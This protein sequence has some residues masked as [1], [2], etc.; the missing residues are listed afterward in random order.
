MRYAG[1]GLLAA[2]VLLSGGAAYAQ[3]AAGPEGGGA[4]GFAGDP[5]PGSL[6]HAAPVTDQRVGLVRHNKGPETLRVAPGLA[7]KMAVK[8]NPDGSP[9]NLLE[10]MQDKAA[11]KR[12]SEGM[13]RGV[14]TNQRWEAAQRH[15][16]RRAAEVRDNEARGARPSGQEGGAK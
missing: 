2:A 8:L 4:A 14:T 3:T 5:K 11:A 10:E 7:D 1:V 9:R 12:A 15:A 13:M 6:A 16:D